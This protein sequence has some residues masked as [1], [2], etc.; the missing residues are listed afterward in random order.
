MYIKFNASKCQEGNMFCYVVN[1]KT[2]TVDR[3][4]VL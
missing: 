3:E 1:E 2:I 4:W